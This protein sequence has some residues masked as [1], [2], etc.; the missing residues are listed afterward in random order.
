MEK[1]VRPILGISKCLEFDNCRYDGKIIGMEFIRN[2]KKYVDFLPVCPEVGIGLGTPRKPIRLVKINGKKNLYQPSSGQNLTEKMTQFSE[3]FLNP[4]K[5]I[6]GF[7][8]KNASPTCGIRNVKLYHKIGKEVS[9]DRTTGIFTESINKKFPH[10]VIEDEKRLQNIVLRDSF[11]TRLY[12][13][14]NL[15]VALSSGSHDDFSKFYLNH[16]MLFMCYDI[17]KTKKI[18]DMVAKQNLK[19]P[20]NDEVIKKMV[21]ELMNKIPDSNSYFNTYMYIFHSIENRLENSEKQY[22]KS[23]MDDFTRGSVSYSQVS[24]LLYSWALRFELHDLISQTI[25]NPYPKELLQD[26]LNDKRKHSLLGH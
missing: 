12:A 1:P 2:M 18:G 19:V 10:I 13:M 16:K 20:R 6:D 4:I 9:Y 21:F 15:R 17:E 23:L 22:F 14:A 26:L 5:S 24:T 11:L 3:K 8:L 7:I 25:F